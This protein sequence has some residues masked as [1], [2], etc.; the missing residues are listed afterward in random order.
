MGRRTVRPGRRW[1]SSRNLSF[2]KTYTL[3]FGETFHRPTLRSQPFVVV[4]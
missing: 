3:R 4:M 2:P 1:I